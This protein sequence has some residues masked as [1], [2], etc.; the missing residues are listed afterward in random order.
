M[1]T[2]FHH[3]MSTASRFVR[4]GLSE[5]DVE[6]DLVEEKPWS[7]RP[8]F[9]ALNP[10]GTLPVM[11]AEREH[12]LSGA[13]VI[14]EY[15]DETRGAFKRERR[16]LAEDP[17]ERAETRRLCDWFLTKMENEVTKHLVRE[18]IFKLL[19]TAEEG[20]GA[21]D[22][23]SMRAARA[24]VRQHMKYLNWLSG[25]RDWI[26]GTRFSFADLAAAA[27]ISV[28]DY[29]GEVSWKEADAARDWY[30]RVKSR[31]SMRPL[32]ADRVRVITPASHYPV[33]DF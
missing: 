4:L 12:K 13:M 2:L 10:A 24:N 16:L 30:I 21:P 23:A 6:F 17:F 26:A 29:M 20:G 14:A 31:P 15:L 1:L 3:P 9:L 32:L 19:M 22:S 25:T 7:R 5:Y 18:R 27:A 33:L 11:V 8:E 28:L